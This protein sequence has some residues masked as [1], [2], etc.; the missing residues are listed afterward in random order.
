MAVVHDRHGN[1]F[2]VACRAGADGASID[3]GEPVL[4][5]RYD[6]TDQTFTVVPYELGRD[7]SSGGRTT[8]TRTETSLA[9][10]APPT[11]RVTREPNAR[12][13]SS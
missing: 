4:L 13:S 10:D 9:P 7:A 6:E 12:E 11:L 2:Q 5:V 1:R 3:K 8:T